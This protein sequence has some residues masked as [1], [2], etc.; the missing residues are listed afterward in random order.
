MAYADGYDVLKNAK[1][2]L[3]VLVTNGALAVELFLKSLAGKYV[4]E[5]EIEEVVSSSTKFWVG[6]SKQFVERGVGHKFTKIFQTIPVATQEK[7]RSLWE[8]L[9]FDEDLELRLE[10]L[11]DDFINSRYC[12]Q[13]GLKFE[14]SLSD[15]DELIRLFRDYEPNFK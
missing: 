11:G 6:R 2:P 15:Y 4:I 12:D 3:F 5:D 8:H 14:G 9:G 13:S 7:I 1:L 10:R